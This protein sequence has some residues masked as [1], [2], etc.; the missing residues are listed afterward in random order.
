MQEVVRR[1]ADKEG[2]DVAVRIGVHTGIVTGGIIGTVRFHFDM[3]GAGVNGSVKMEESGERFRVHVSDSTYALMWHH[4]ECEPGKHSTASGPPSAH[5]FQLMSCAPCPR[6]VRVTHV[7]HL[8]CVQTVGGTPAQQ[9]A[10]LARRRF[11]CLPFSARSRRPRFC[12]A[13]N[14]SQTYPEAGAW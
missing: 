11:S 3:W 13:P 8:P 1:V 2:V 7:V 10:A 14:S 6:V 4:F 12:A 5:E 9:P